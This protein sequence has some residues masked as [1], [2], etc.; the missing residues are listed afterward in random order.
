MYGVAPVS[1]GIGSHPILTKCSNEI[2][3]GNWR[4]IRIVWSLS[5]STALSVL[6]GFPAVCRRVFFTP[7]MMALPILV[8]P[9]LGYDGTDRAIAEKQ[10]FW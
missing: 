7:M 8:W 6:T 4:A 5:W 9:S 10:T 1:A 2:K 3:R